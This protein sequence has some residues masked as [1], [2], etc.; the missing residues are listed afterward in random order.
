M[1]GE[2]REELVETSGDAYIYS[3]LELEA[4]LR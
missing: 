2:E 4:C 1:G 3:S